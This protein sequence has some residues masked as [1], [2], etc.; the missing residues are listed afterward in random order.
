MLFRIF[1]A[2]GKPSFILHVRVLLFKWFPTDVHFPAFLDN[3]N[4]FFSFCRSSLWLNLSVTIAVDRSLVFPVFSAAGKVS[5]IS[6]FRVYFFQS[7]LQATFV[8]PPFWTRLTVFFHFAGFP[9]VESFFVPKLSRFS[10][11]GKSLS[12]LLLHYSKCPSCG[13]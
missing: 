2:A 5:F 4:G 3:G 7:R 11:K 1:C 6:H 10:F 8:F 13:H 9:L 12:V